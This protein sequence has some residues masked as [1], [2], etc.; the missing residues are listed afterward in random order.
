MATEYYVIYEEAQYACVDIPLVLFEE[1]LYTLPQ[2]TA[3]MP[4]TYTSAILLCAFAL[5]LTCVILLVIERR[6][7]MY[8][9]EYRRGKQ[10]CSICNAQPQSKDR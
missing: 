7:R 6:R 3:F 8:Y 4:T 5:L 1:T 9:A 2:G 10:Q